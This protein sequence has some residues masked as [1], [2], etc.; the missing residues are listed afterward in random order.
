MAYDGVIDDVR[1]AVALEKPQ[2]LP[3]FSCSEEFDVKWYGRYTYEE[4]CQDGDKMAEVMKLAE[5]NCPVSGVI[6]CPVEL[7]LD[8][9]VGE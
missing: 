1:R 6:K 3:V 9:R 2:R 7:S 4:V 8:C 5:K